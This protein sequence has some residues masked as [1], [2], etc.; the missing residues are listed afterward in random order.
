M[1]LSHLHGGHCCDDN[2]EHVIN[3]LK[4]NDMYI[5]VVPQR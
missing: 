4:P 1:V 2:V 3:L 5:Y